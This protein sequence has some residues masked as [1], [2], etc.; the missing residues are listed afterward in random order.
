MV[1]A[2]WMYTILVAVMIL[3]CSVSLMIPTAA[4]QDSESGGFLMELF[5]LLLLV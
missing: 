3:P 5:F 4:F 1:M 2:L